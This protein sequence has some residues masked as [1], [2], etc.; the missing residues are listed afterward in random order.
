MKRNWM[1]N[2]IFGLSFTSALFIFQACYGTPQDMLFDAHIHGKVLSKSSGHPIPG[3]KISVANETQH[4]YSGEDGGFSFY[5]L[6]SETMTLR[7]EDVDST[8][9]GYFKEREAVFRDF[10]NDVYMEIELEEK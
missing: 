10:D 2:A 8:E 9:N 3:I 5:T 7:F 6:L 4:T 1:K